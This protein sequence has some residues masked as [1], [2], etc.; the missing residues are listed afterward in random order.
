MGPPKWLIRH[1]KGIFLGAIA[2][3]AAVS[4]L[5]SFFAGEKRREGQLRRANPS[6]PPE[7]SV[8]ATVRA[9]T[10]TPMTP[11]RRQMEFERLA[12]QGD[13]AAVEA[14]LSLVEHPQYGKA[15][16]F[17]L[18]E[19]RL[20]EQRERSSEVVRREM[21]S[22]DEEKAAV[23]AAVY[24]DLKGGEAVPALVEFLH[25]HRAQSNRNAEELCALGARLLGEIGTASAQAALIGELARAA[26]P[27]WPL[28]YGSVLVRS[29]ARSFTGNTSAAMKEEGQLDRSLVA[30]AVLGYAETLARRMPQ[31]GQERKVYEQ[32]IVE[33]REI[34][35]RISR[36]QES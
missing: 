26:S 35:S 23:A 24:A 34:A 11:R 22:S 4:L 7:D 21:G 2:V 31:E 20:P 18:R 1:G 29:L 28:N 10:S 27:E 25:R 3:T 13:D 17:A 16:L 33:A 6:Q 30:A 8:W 15:A 9:L 5:S 12:Q 14:L 36:G 19:V 32:K